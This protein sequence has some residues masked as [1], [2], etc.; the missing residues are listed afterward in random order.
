MFCPFPHEF[1]VQLEQPI[2]EEYI[3][4]EVS[5]HLYIML[6]LEDE[7]FYCTQGSSDGISEGLRGSLWD[8]PLE[9]L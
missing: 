4:T 3:A 5:L 6:T 2:V 7:P 9:Q 8:G 1:R